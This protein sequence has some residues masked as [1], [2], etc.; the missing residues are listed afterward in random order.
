MFSIKATGYQLIFRQRFLTLFSLQSNK[1]VK[2]DA[3]RFDK[4][5][6]DYDENFLD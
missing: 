5:A 6:S 3:C 2:F 4:K 1:K